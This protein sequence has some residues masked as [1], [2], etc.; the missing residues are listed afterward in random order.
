MDRII[1]PRIPLLAHI[2]VT[3]RERASEQDILIDLEL[4]LDLSAAGKEDALE[5]TVDYERVCDVVA[6][7]VRTRAFRLL[8][9]AAEACA[10]GILDT[11]QRV[12]EVR[13]CIRKPGA[14]R[15]RGVS[16]AAVEVVRRRD[17]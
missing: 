10:Q 9:A 3:E 16:Y 4:G 6:T 15:S 5:L 17:S 14:L 13:V 2:G 7:L 11:F 8:E 1:V 12:A